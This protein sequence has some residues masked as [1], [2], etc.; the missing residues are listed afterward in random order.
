[1]EL[2][3]EPGD[4]YSTKSTGPSP[5]LLRP[6]ADPSLDTDSCKLARDLPA[7]D[8]EHPD[9]A[10]RPPRGWNEVDAA[11]KLSSGLRANQSWFLGKYYWSFASVPD[12]QYP[13]T[14]LGYT[15]DWAPKEDGGDD[16]V[17]RGEDEYVIQGKT[18]LKF[19]S[20]LSTLEYCT[21]H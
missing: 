4:L 12:H 20:S 21:P 5:K 7:P 19:V 18:K 1:V 9:I 6:C 2:T 16:F 8:P 3:I 13:W 11:S 14:S 15:F 10:A 17:R